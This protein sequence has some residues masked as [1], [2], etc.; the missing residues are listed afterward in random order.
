LDF[1]QK[2]TKAAKIIADYLE[3]FTGGNEGKEEGGHSNRA[4]FA[5]SKSDRRRKQRCLALDFGQD[6]V[7]AKHNLSSLRYLLFKW[8]PNVESAFVSPAKV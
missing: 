2:E 8:D 3:F 5:W 6:L 1:L 4:D 7:L